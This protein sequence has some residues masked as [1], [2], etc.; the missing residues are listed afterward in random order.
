MAVRSSLRPLQTLL[1]VIVGLGLGFCS[2]PA[3]LDSEVALIQAIVRISTRL[4]R[5]ISYRNAPIRRGI[6][7]SGVFRFLAI[8][9]KMAHNLLN[10][11]ILHHPT[12]CIQLIATSRPRKNGYHDYLS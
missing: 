10:H 4:L 2:T 8:A 5:P 1:R 7:S 9:L 11:G 6:I 12:P 3:D